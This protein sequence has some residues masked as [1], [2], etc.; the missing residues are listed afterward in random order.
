LSGALEQKRIE[1]SLSRLSPATS[2]QTIGSAA[3]EPI[4]E[5]GPRVWI[6]FAPAAESGSE[7]LTFVA[8]DGQALRGEALLAPELG[9]NALP[10]LDGVNSADLQADEIAGRQFAV[11]RE[12]EQHQI[13]D[14]TFRPQ[15]VSDH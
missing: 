11:K 10:H 4:T 7:L 14:T 8:I 12:I 3:A 1:P 5:V 13:A 2:L 9:R 15:A 6:R